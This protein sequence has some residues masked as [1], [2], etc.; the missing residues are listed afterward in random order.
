MFDCSLKV[1]KA[2]NLQH[3]TTSTVDGKWVK[4]PKLEVPTFDGDILD[5]KTF[6]EQ[7]SVSIHTRPNLSRN[8][9]KYSMQ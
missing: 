3:G 5:W 2:L 9:S 1:K 4:L 7:F 6:W 8:W